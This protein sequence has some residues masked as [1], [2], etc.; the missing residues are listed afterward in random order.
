[1]SAPFSGSRKCRCVLCAATLHP[2]SH[3]QSNWDISEHHAGRLAL[4]LGTSPFLGQAHSWDMPLGQAHSWDRK[5]REFSAAWSILV[6]KATHIHPLNGPKGRLLIKEQERLCWQ[7]V[8]TAETYKHL[9]AIT[10]LGCQVQHSSRARCPRNHLRGRKASPK[11]FEWR[12][13][14]SLSLPLVREESYLII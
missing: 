11:P 6:Q 9:T 10:S 12:Q 1:M 4:H 3:K 5:L 2:V 8:R 7:L 13:V 14:L